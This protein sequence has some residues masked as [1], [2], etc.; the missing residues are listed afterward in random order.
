MVTLPTNTCGNVSMSRAGSKAATGTGVSV[1][2]G[3]GDGVGVAVGVA[4]GV[5]MG[6]AVGV[7]VSVGCGVGVAVGAR[8]AVGAMVRSTSEAQADKTNPIAIKAIRAPFSFIERD[9]M[10]YDLYLRP[11]EKSV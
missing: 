6:V 11:E 8:V 1:G 2:V 3:V 10:F 4:V 5:G 7:G 9:S